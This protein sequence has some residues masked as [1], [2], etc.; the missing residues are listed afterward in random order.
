M[1][2]RESFW[3]ARS[4]VC[5]RRGVAGKEEVSTTA[6]GVVDSWGLPDSLRCRRFVKGDRGGGRNKRSEICL[7]GERWFSCRAGEA[8]AEERLDSL[9][10]GVIFF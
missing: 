3:L 9:Y 4:I 7:S 10:V 1:L 2:L 6:G 5:R 8:R